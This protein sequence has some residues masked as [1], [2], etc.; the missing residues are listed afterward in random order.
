MACGVLAGASIP[1]QAM[2]SSPGTPASVT[3]GTSGVAAES[4]GP[5]VASEHRRPDFT[6]GM[7][8]A[9]GTSENC[10]SFASSAVVAGAMP[11]YA[12]WVICAP[13]SDR[14]SSV[15]RWGELPGPDEP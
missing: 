8:T 12:V 7:P 4:T 3:V 11:L 13:V 14:N 10:T 5:Q 2:T 15:A 9:I 1:H 6:C